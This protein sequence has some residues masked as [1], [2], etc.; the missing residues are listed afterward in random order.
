MGRRSLKN[1]QC[2]YF[3]ILVIIFIVSMFSKS[4][5]AKEV[6]LD[7]LLAEVNG[8]VITYSE[9]KVKVEDGP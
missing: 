5:D 4:A 2:N 8:E 9:V 6:L 1:G 7:R 3:Q